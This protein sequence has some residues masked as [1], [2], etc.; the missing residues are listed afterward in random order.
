MTVTRLEY[1]TRDWRI[2]MEDDEW[3]YLVAEFS[4]WQAAMSYVDREA[5]MWNRRFL[6]ASGRYGRRSPVR[7]LVYPAAREG[8]GPR[9]RWHQ[10]GDARK[11]QTKPCNCSA[12]RDHE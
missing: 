9:E 7:W 6:V 2:P 3:A 5:H 1:E 4:D 10:R 8:L 12:A 11:G